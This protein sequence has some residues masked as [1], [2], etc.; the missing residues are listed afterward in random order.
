MKK[1]IILSVLVIIL[2][3]ASFIA[4]KIFGPSVQSKDVQYL[5]IRTGSS[6]KDLKK[7]LIDKKF[8]ASSAQFSQV[9]KLLKY[10]NVKPGRYKVYDGMSVYE[11]VRMLRGGVQ[12]P[13]NLVITKLRTKEDLARR[14]GNIF[15]CDSLQLIRFLSSN[16]SLKQFEVDTTTVM[17]LVLPLTYSGNWNSTPQKIMLRFQT[18][19]KE[20]WNNERKQ[21]AT[22]LGLTPIQVSTLAS[23]IDE[24]TNKASDRPNVASVYLNRI[25][26]GMPL[27]AD[28]TVKFALKNFALKRVLNAHL[29][30]KSPYNTYLNAGLPPGPICT[31][32]TE[33]IDAVLN[34]PKTEYLYFVA[35][36][37]FDGTHVFTTN[38]A[39]HLKYAR[40]YQTA[41]TK[42]L[43]SANKK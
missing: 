12:T 8:I 9:A 4:Y 20:F 29:E 33:T 15:E 18:A 32:Q 16:D 31:A 22:T 41:L 21:K 24:E 7:E 5:F 1:K 34:A 36:S 40:E 35:N 17:T 14:A 38:Y 3:A 11:L 42:L 28:P 23:I 10:K 26:Q 13:V 27:Q 19:W 2:I 30:T 25:K 6:M 43:D 39:D 37:A